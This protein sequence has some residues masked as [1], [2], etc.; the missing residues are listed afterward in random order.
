[1][2]P[3]VNVLPPMARLVG[4]PVAIKPDAREYCSLR[5]LPLGAMTWIL[6]LLGPALVEEPGTFVALPP[7]NTEGGDPEFPTLEITDDASG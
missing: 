4:F 1:M 7:F 2:P 3:G 5:P 6:L